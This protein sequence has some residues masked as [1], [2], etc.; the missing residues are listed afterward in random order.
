MNRFQEGMSFLEKARKEKQTDEH[1]VID[2][3]FAE[4]GGTC[5]CSLSTGLSDALGGVAGF[6]VFVAP[7]NDSTKLTWHSFSIPVGVLYRPPESKLKNLKAKNY[8]GQAK[9]VSLCILD[10]RD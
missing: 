2:E 7:K 4:Q 3:A 8:L 5:H 9:L 10:D 6:T 1:N